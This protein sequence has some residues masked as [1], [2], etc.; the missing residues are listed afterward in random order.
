MKL[1]NLTP[2]SWATASIEWTTLAMLKKREG[3]NFHEGPATDWKGALIWFPSSGDNFTSAKWAIGM[4]KRLDDGCGHCETH[5]R[6]L[7]GLT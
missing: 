2:I 6:K 7:M 5:R 1:P 3:I 4:I